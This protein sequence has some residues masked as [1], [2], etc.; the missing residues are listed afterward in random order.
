[1][2]VLRDELQ[3]KDAKIDTRLATMED[4]MAEMLA[5]MRQAQPQAAGQSQERE[6][7]GR[8]QGSKSPVK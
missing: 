6:V 2:K 5:L 1:M 7:E 8:A 3:G 4:Q